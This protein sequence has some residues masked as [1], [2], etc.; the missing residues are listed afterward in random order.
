MQFSARSA[1]R[2]AVLCAISSAFIAVAQTSLPAPK[3]L[4]STDYKEGKVHGYIVNPTSGSIKPTGQTPQWAHWGPT[5]VASDKGGYRLYVIN[6][7]SADLNAYFIYRNNG[8]IYSVPGSPFKIG[9]AP[10]DVGVHPSGDYVYVTAQSNWVYAFHVQ[11]NGSLAAVPGSPFTTV[12]KPQALAIDP[13]GKYLFVSSYPATSTPSKSEVEA[14]SINSTDGALTPVPG[15][16]YVEPNSP[17]CANGA[18]D[19]AVHPS[20]NFLVLP[21]MCEGIVVYRISR[22]TGTLS[23]VKGSPFP[24]PYPPYPVVE[25]IAMD[26]RGQYIWISSQYC[27]SGCGQSTDT[28]RFNATTGVPT[29]LESGESACGLLARADPSGKFLYVIGDTQG[30]GCAGTDLTPGIW[31]M[32]VNRTNGAVKN[33]SGSPWAS[34]NSDFFLADG[35]AITP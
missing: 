33:I 31:G 19:M 18:W 23:L 14:F 1:F 15:S 26:P 29:Y 20:G 22:S 16:P 24:V 21:N 34:P 32:S 9:Q 4:Y 25:S 13:Q 11:S 6:Q 7:G 35:L 3:F 2:A 30:L 8:Y 12:S 27:H 28:W 10:T 17:Y 5:R